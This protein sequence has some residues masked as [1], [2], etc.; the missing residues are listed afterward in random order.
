MKTLED[1]NKKWWYRF[2]KVIFGVSL[3]VVLG[4]INVIA[5]SGEVKKVDLNNTTIEC[6]KTIK[7]SFSAQDISLD[8]RSNNFPDGN[9][10]YK[11]FF[12]NTD[13]FELNKIF[14]K[15]FPDT[16]GNSL[17]IQL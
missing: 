16:I 17:G 9:F 4:V 6:S 1:L 11:T 13:E 8:L 5:F 14:T 12:E 7:N 2:L 3:L 10:N 15:C